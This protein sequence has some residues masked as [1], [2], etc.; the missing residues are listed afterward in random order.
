[1]RAVVEPT[2]AQLGDTIRFGIIVDNSRNPSVQTLTLP[3]TISAGSPS[4][5]QNLQTSSINGRVQQ[6]VTTTIVYPLTVTREGSYTIPSQTVVVDGQ[7]YTTDPARFTVTEPPESEFHHL[8]LEPSE[9]SVYIGQPLTLRVKWLLREEPNNHDFRLNVA[10]AHLDVY[11]SKRRGNFAN[12]INF[13]DT[14]VIPDYSEEYYEGIPYYVLSWDVIVVPRVAGA[15]SVGPVMGTFQEISGYRNRGF[16]RDAVYTRSVAKSETIRISVKQLPPEAPR[17]FSGLVGQ[18][19]I[20]AEVSPDEG[21]VGDPLTLRVKIG[22]TEPLERIDPPSL[23]FLAESFRLSPEGWVDVE[24]PTPDLRIFETTIRATTD[25]IDALPPVE[26]AYLDPVEGEYRLATSRPYPLTIHPTRQITADDALIA[27]SPSGVS[28]L[29]TPIQTT[30]ALAPMRV[31]ANRSTESLATT[32]RV[33]LLAMMSTPIGMAITGAPPAAFALAIALTAIRTRRDPVR[34]RQRGALRRASA[35]LHA[36]EPLKASQRFLSDWF[37]LESD[38]V[39]SRDSRV[40]L[41]E[42]IDDQKA[43]RL[44][45]QMEYLERATIEKNLRVPLASEMEATLTAIHKE[46]LRCV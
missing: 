21:N 36:G 10:P 30:L 44:E 11:P 41:E 40:L 13:E 25:S 6:S 35:L 4:T 45:K 12:P 27:S 19:V 1:V 17:N 38:A 2:R 8:V 5:S 16:L 43:E 46:L 42:R 3:E 28:T 23:D 7:T 26:L 20:A 9:E 22:G 39:T 18:H 34:T 33:D 14:H 24:S 32:E 31:R 15:L 29:R 37:E